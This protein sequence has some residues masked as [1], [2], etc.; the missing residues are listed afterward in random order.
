MGIKK[1]SFYSHFESKKELLDTLVREIEERYEAYSKTMKK[2]CEE[3][4]RWTAEDVFQ[5][6]NRQ[7]EFLIHDSF[8]AEQG[9]F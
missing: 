4:I 2:E 5:S 3:S 9:I 1:A 8:F 7:F 6:V